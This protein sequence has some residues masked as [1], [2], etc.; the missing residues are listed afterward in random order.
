MILFVVACRVICAKDILMALVVHIE[1]SRCHLVAQ[2]PT[3]TTFLRL[4]SSP[5]NSIVSRMIGCTTLL[6]YRALGGALMRPALLASE[7]GM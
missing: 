7:G 5:P 4:L 1:L 6:D 2:A 3:F